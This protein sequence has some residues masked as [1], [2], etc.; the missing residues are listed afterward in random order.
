[1]VDVHM[2]AG[3][4]P[5]SSFSAMGIAT[6]GGELGF[7]YMDLRNHIQRTKTIM[8]EHGAVDFLLQYFADKGNNNA[9]FYHKMKIYKDGEIESVFW[10]DTRIQMDY[11]YFRDCISFD[12][13]Y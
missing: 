2:A 8:I 11:Q 3:I 4:Q 6:G 9:G 10:A 12:T 1:M 5:R 13:T 7:T